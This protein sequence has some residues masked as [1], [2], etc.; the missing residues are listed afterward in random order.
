M[1]FN[2]G[3]E[4]TILYDPATLREIARNGGCRVKPLQS[5]DHIRRLLKQGVELAL[6]GDLQAVPKIAEDFLYDYTQLY[7]LLGK[8]TADL[9]VRALNEL[10]IELVPSRA[11]DPEVFKALW[12]L[13]KEVVSD[14]TA[15]RRK[16]KVRDLLNAFERQWETPLTA[17]EVAYPVDYLDLG[18]K[19]VSVGSVTF[20]TADENALAEWGI[21]EAHRNSWGSEDSRV[22][23]RCISCTQVE[24]AHRRLVFELKV[25][26]EAASRETEA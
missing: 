21:D 15:Y 25:T 16:G 17:F 26:C 22:G 1:K 14:L 4:G 8:Q 11:D 20:R 6:S 23:S 2:H 9:Y 12:E 10:R 3:E 13:F 24:A 19:P 7:F 5:K 18:S